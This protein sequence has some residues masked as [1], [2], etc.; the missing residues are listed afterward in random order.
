[1]FLTVKKRSLGSHTSCGWGLKNSNLGLPK[2]GT[3]N[4]IICQ[5]YSL[6]HLLDDKL[7]IFS[8]EPADKIPVILDKGDFSDMAPETL[9]RVTVSAF[10]KIISDQQ[11]T[12]MSLQE[13]IASLT[14][15]NQSQQQL[16][17]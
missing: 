5:T 12:I 2:Q 15:V 13:D 14:A 3:R 4:L 11:L 7:L 6:H 16:L 8:Y 9:E 17:R 1:M 10:L